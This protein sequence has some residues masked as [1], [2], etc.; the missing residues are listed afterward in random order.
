MVSSIGATSTPSR[1]N[2]AISYLA[3]WATFR[4]VGSSSRPCSRSS[5]AANGIWPR[6][7]SVSS[8]S[9]PSAAAWPSGT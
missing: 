1:R 5:A 7:L 8:A 4:T 2:T 3:L 6:S 9:P